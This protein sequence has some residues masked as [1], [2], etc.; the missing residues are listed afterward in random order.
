MVAS[1]QKRRKKWDVH[2]MK[3]LASLFLAI[4]TLAALSCPVKSQDLA[5]Y[6][7]PFTGK[8]VA[9]DDAM[10]LDDY[11]LQ[12]I[13]NVRK[14]GKHFKGVS[15]HTAINSAA[16]STSGTSYSS[17]LSGFHFHKDQP[18]E[19]HVIIY[20]A[21]TT[22]TPTAGILFQSATAIPG[23]GDFSS[24][25]L[26]SPSA[27]NNIWRFSSAPGGNMV[28]ANGD[29]TLIWGGNE[30]EAT[31]F[32]TSSAAVVYT[33]TNPNDYSSQVSNTLSTADQVALVGGHIDTYTVLLLHGDGTDASTTITDSE[34]TPKAV[35]AADDAQ[36]DTAQLK[37]GSGSI[38]FDGTGDY[39]TTADHADW[40]MADGKFTIDFWV[41]FAA[42][43]ADGQSMILYSQR[44]DADNHAVL[45]LGFVD[46]QPNAYPV[47]QNGGYVVT[48][49]DTTNYLS[50]YATDP[51]LSLTGAAANNSWKTAPAVV[52]NQRF[53][54]DVGTAHTI[55]RIY[56]ENYHDSGGDTDK[57]AQ[58]FTLWGSNGDGAYV[59]ASGGTITYTDSSGLNPRASPAYAGGY[60]VHTF[61]SSG[62][63][64]VARAGDVEYLVVAGGGGGGITTDGNGGAG[65]GGGGGYK[66]GT[67]TLTAGNKVVTV[68]AGGT[69]HTKGGN[70]VFDS[71]VSTGGGG[72]GTAPSEAGGVGGSGAGGNY[73]AGAG[74]AASPAG[75]GYAGGNGAG[76]G[77]Y[78]G[79][80][81]GASEVGHVGTGSDGKG[82]DGLASSI[83]GTATTRAGGGGGGA[84]GAGGAGGGGAGGTPGGN[85]GTANTGG[86]GGGGY[87]G[88]TVTGGH[89]GSGVVII[90]YLSDP[91]FTTTTYGTDTNWTQLATSQSSFDQHAASDAADPKYI[92]VTN[93]T[94]YIYYALKIA[95]NYGDT[96]SLGIRRI[97]LR[98]T[99]ATGVYSFTHSLKTAG[100]EAIPINAVAWATPLINTW[101]HVALQR[102]W[103]GAANKW[104]IAVNG[105]SLG[106]TTLATTYPNVAAALQIGAG[107]TGIGFNGW[108][109]EFRIS[110]GTARWTSNFTPTTRAYATGSN[111]WLVGSKRPLK[112][113]KF[114]VSDP[115]NVT[116]T[117]LT[118]GWNGTSWTTLTT[119]DNTWAGGVTLAQTGTVTWPSTVAT[120]VPRYINGLSLYW[121]QFEISAGAATIYSVTVDAPMQTMKNIWD[122]VE[123]YTVKCL[124]YDGTTYK[125][126]TNQVNDG[127]QSTYADF[128]NLATTHAIYL[129]FLNPQQ[130]VNF[131]FVAGA[132][133]STAATQ[134][135][136][137]YWNGESWTTAGATNDATMTTTTS[138]SKGGVVSFQ[139]ATKGTEFKR[140]ISDEY[141][142]YYYRVTFG[143]NL[144]TDVKVSEIT[145]IAYPDTVAAYK[146]SETFQNRLFLFNEKSGDKNKAIYSTYN[147]PDI[148]NGDD[149]GEITFGDRQELTAAVVLYNIYTNTAVEQMLVTKRNET[150]RISGTNPSN[151][152]LHK[153]S[154]N[155]GCVAPLSMV[156]AEMTESADIK[157]TVAIWQSDKAIVMSDGATIVPISDDIKCYF[158]PNDA[159]YIP[160]DWQSRSVAWY[161]SD[162]RAYK[163]LIASG[164]GATYLNTELEYSLKHKE[165]TKIY[166][167]NASGAN[168]LQSGWPVFSTTGTGYTYGGGKDGFVYRLEN[169]NNWNSTANITSYLHTKDLI[170][171]NTAP[172]LYKSTIKYLRSTWKKKAM[173]NLTVSHYGDK[174]ITTSGTSGQ[175]GPA[176]ITSGGS[177]F[178]NTQ[179]TILGPWLT[180]SLKFQATTNVSDGME[181][182]GVGIYYQPSATIR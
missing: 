14:D 140:A 52:T 54:I 157:R 161:D 116:S 100:E 72:G 19:S 74:G 159:R 61:T 136:L 24:T 168:P 53:H 91:T 39:L 134:M 73:N 99:G 45:S 92:D 80:G 6:V 145:G 115:N 179:S 105:T 137:A 23:T 151:W 108:I 38:L 111:Y 8:W 33:L 173:G 125:D 31:S 97:V 169:G 176:I 120:S 110:K 162:K 148:M 122:G 4:L 12:D 89:G 17:I 101:Y 172:L 85:D 106:S 181:L 76:A 133:N 63:F 82:G 78:G 15:G 67:L 47:A 135:T 178:Y 158:D 90:R 34:T 18:A 35:T 41:R 119:S 107:A 69:D 55:K 143:G 77:A 50:Y 129:G 60:K 104:S 96:A 130:C 29:E 44:A 102:G 94:P 20:A 7:F 98:E 46:A 2:D 142:L 3:K 177:T 51:A 21:D 170:L 56:Y 146:F 32:V 126:Y 123:E 147:A 109:D 154:S 131:T 132:E 64:T 124:K 144:D 141:P 165:W 26:W 155:I 62:T 13:Q 40:Y 117:L 65:G 167:E 16:P 113:V 175:M 163:L 48:T 166:R 182:L 149:Y 57:G 81:G 49:S 1:I 11:G 114:Y 71:I 25:A 5:P 153:M 83:S 164:A 75:E 103:D 84:S 160:A 95:D 42:L 87:G 174:I 30:I 138:F 70:S 86:G 59:A 68:G 88:T 9:S 121:Y 180:Q 128:S 28:A 150:Y 22:E 152:I 156:S 66:T 127:S 171:G 112:G 10:L 36:I 27:F 118:K 79:G 58:N 37:Y 139:G 43:P 93:D